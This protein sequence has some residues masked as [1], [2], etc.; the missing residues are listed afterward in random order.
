MKPLLRMYVTALFEDIY[1]RTI[2]FSFRVALCRPM[3]PRVVSHSCPEHHAD[4]DP[5]MTALNDMTLPRKLVWL[6]GLVLAPPVFTLLFITLFGWN[7]LRV[8]IER[9]VMDKTGRELAIK[10][11]ITIRFGWPLPHIRAAGVSF[12]NPSWALEK[13]MLS[14]EAVDIT[15][16]AVQLLHRN[17]V[18]PEVHL[19]RPLVFLER[20]TGGRKNWLLDLAQQDESARIRIGRLTLDQGRI[21]YDDME[22]T[23]RIRVDLS[24]AL[25]ISTQN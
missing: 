18:L 11:D 21:G 6:A 7:W 2:L 8:P 15:F 4:C 24:S 10:G 1:R 3:S 16:D 9:V 12:A 25:L 13:E 22:Q 5:Q 19:T 14:A 20:G 17:V 23:T